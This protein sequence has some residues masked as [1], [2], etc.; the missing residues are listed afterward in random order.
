MEVPVFSSI[1]NS[2]SLMFYFTGRATLAMLLGMKPIP[3]AAAK[4]HSLSS[5]PPEN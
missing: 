5:P 2:L 1:S 3:N 4:L